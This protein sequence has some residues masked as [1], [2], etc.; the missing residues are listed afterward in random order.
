MGDE[1]GMALEYN[2]GYTDDGNIFLDF[3]A[4]GPDGTP[5]NATLVVTRAV[6]DGLIKDLQNAIDQSY[7]GGKI[8]S[9]Q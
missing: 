6:A 1:R 5:L 7:R 9:L 8:I 3:K 2:V 4:Q